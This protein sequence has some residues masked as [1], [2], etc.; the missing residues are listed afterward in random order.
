MHLNTSP[1]PPVPKRWPKSKSSTTHGC[2][3]C[4]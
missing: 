4:T 1:D 3:G 2:W